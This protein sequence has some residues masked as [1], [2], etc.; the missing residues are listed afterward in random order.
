MTERQ[1]SINTADEAA[2]TLSDKS[3]AAFLGHVNSI[4]SYIGGPI[5]RDEV[6]DVLST[7][8]IFIGDFLADS[9][10]EV[11]EDLLELIEDSRFPELVRDAN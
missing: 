2:V 8:P 9:A 7:N 11:T 4:A 6:L 10:T 1:L 3:I 5:T